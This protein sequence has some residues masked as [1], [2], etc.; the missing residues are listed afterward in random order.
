[1]RRG[2]AWLAGG[3]GMCG[4]EILIVMGCRWESRLGVGEE[5]CLFFRFPFTSVHRRR[6]C[7]SKV[8]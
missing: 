6:I 1:M 3:M 4:C 2:E 5:P 7:K 8:V